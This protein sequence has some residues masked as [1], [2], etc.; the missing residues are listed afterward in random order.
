[1]EFLNKAIFGL[2]TFVS[3]AASALWNNISVSQYSPF[4]ITA[5]IVLV[6]IIFY[7]IIMIIRGTR[8]TNILFGVGVLAFVFA[9][10]RWLNLIALG[11][12]LERLLTVVLIAIPIIFQQ[13]LRRGLEKLGHTKFFLA[14]EAQH[15]DALR[16]IVLESIAELGKKRQGALIVFHGDSSLREYIDTGVRLNAKPSKELLMALF[17]PGSPL[18]DGAVIL[19]RNEIVAAGCVLPHSLKEYGHTFGTR[20]KSALALSE[21]SDAKIFIVSEER[22]SISYAATGEMERDIT[23]ERARHLLKEILRPQNGRHPFL[24]NHVASPSS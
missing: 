23:L 17:S 12:L 8:G 1:M 21:A 15:I 6:A 14:R 19:D 22:G 10:S 16:N 18:H 2:V 24:K 13:E 20:H 7:W 4:Q 11:W 9:L 3:D 5:D